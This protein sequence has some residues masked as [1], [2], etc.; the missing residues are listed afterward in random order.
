MEGGIRPIPGY[1]DGVAAEG[2]EKSSYL[3]EKK[4]GS[5]FLLPGFM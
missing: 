5:S 3:P 2:E 4:G 1:A